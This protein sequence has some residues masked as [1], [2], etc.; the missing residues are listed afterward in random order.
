VVRGTRLLASERLDQETLATRLT[1][2]RVVLLGEEHFTNELPAYG[3]GVIEKIHAHTGRPVVLLLELPEG[4]QSSI[5]K[6]LRT[7]DEAALANG[8]PSAGTDC[9]ADQR[10]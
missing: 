7:G 10:C 6:Y 4:A 2:S 3:L 1:A 8:C 5:E 9:R